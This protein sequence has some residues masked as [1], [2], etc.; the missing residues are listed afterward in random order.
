[1]KTHTKRKKIA[2]IG[3]GISGLG[4]AYL[5]HPHHDITLY[6]KNDYIGGHSRTLEVQT[7]DGM[8]PVD[9]GFIVFNYRNYPLL[10]K[11]F[12]HLH[13]PVAKSDMSFGVSID[14]GWLEYGTRRMHDLFAQR[15]NLLRPAFWRMIADILKFNASA[16]Q[17]LTADPSI[18]IGECLETLGMG[19]WFRDYFLLAMGGAIW[20][21]PLEQ[22]LK[23]PA[24][25]FIRFFDNHGLLSVNDQPQWYTVE[26]GSRE[27]VKRLSE[28]FRQ[29]IR[30]STAVQHVRR[31]E[32]AVIV[33]S[34]HGKQ[35]SFDEVIFACHADQALALLE[36]P[37]AE[38]RTVLGGFRYQ[39]NRAVLH[40]DTS[41]M[42]RRKA[43]W[44]SWV[45]LSESQTDQSPNVSLSYWMNNL[46][47]LQ[48]SQPLIVTLNPG[49]EPDPALVYDDHWFEHPVFDE[50]AIMNQS[51]IDSIQGKD[52]LW[53]CGAYQRYGFHED[54]LGSAV[55]MVR[56]MGIEPPWL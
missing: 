52:R 15:G 33:Q 19:P 39:P 56:H 22:M 6:E 27:Y 29:C 36:N 40:R 9:T 55:A 25:T 24:C 49:R 28:P 18:T 50:S 44:S 41:F 42:P 32:E 38:E 14:H 35:D 48:T 31:T 11:L 47:P 34:E 51:R 1:M 20:S 16:K 21:T 3:S 5:L 30:L 7:P 17:F 8:I 12:A 53:F 23:F 37:H 4:A 10:T 13:V 26:G 43:A 46:Q 2:I 54:G 45:Y